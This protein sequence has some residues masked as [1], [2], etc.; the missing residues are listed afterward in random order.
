MH[1]ALLL[2]EGFPVIT[3]LAWKMCDK[4][5]TTISLWPPTN[6]GAKKSA[7]F[8]GIRICINTWKFLGGYAP[9]DMFFSSKK[10]KIW[11]FSVLKLEFG[12]LK[13]NFLLSCWSFRD[14]IWKYMSFLSLDNK[15]KLHLWSSFNAKFGH[16]D[17]SFIQV[18]KCE[19]MDSSPPT[20][21]PTITN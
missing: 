4:T 6:P 5:F 14:M 1:R 7:L 12:I 8:T 21:F 11:N 16:K 13:L 20:I 10:W 9:T 15:F 2:Y 3:T 19:K 17:K 18:I